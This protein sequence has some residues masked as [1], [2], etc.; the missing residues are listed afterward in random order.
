MNNL[1]K[2]ILGIPTESAIPKVEPKYSSQEFSN[3]YNKFLVELDQFLGVKR[4]DLYEDITKFNKFYR[5]NLETQVRHRFFKE[6]TVPLTEIGLELE[7]EF[8]VLEL[9]FKRFLYLTT[10]F[11]NVPMFSE[12]VD[13]LWHCSLMFTENYQNFCREMLGRDRFIHHAPSMNDFSEPEYDSRAFFDLIYSS[14]FNITPFSEDIWG[15]MFTCKLS[16][17]FSTDLIHAGKV[18]L[19]KKELE[20]L[21]FVENIDPVENELE[22]KYFRK[23]GSNPSKII[24]NSM[25][26]HALEGEKLAKNRVIYSQWPSKEILNEKDKHQELLISTIIGWSWLYHS[27]LEVEAG[28][29]EDKGTEADSNYNTVN[30]ETIESPVVQSSTHNSSN[31]SS[32]GSSSCRSSSNNGSSSCSSSSCSSGSS[33]SSC[34]SCSS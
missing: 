14:V 21:V 20:N 10:V 31:Y 15:Q 5:K 7:T 9:E 17:E 6:N 32:C 29:K 19:K 12:E 25:I 34:S 3:K 11:K 16:E 26:N 30:T 8:L 22:E 24:S 4:I 18:H 28:I 27:P 33:S 1:I 2:K 13:E 23:P